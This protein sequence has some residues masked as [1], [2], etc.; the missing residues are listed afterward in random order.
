MGNSA[1]V[2]TQPAD[3]VAAEYS[4]HQGSVRD[5]HHWLAATGIRMPEA[6]G[7]WFPGVHECPFAVRQAVSTA[8]SEL[9]EIV[10]SIKENKAEPRGMG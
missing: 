3:N 9:S 7:G 8:K 6:R 10:W 1:A 5:N 2:F 4:V